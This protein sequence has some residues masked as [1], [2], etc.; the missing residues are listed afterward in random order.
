MKNIQIIINNKIIIKVLDN[1]YKVIT[2]IHKQTNK[3]KMMK[4]ICNW[5]I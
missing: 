2:K 3:K 5:I 4:I 1:K